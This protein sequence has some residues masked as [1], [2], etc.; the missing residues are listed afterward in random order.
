MEMTGRG[1]N[2]AVSQMPIPPTITANQQAAISS[3]LTKHLHPSLTEP[4]PSSSAAR[5]EAKVSKLSGPIKNDASFSAGKDEDWNERKVSSSKSGGSK[6][7]TGTGGD[8]DILDADLE[9][10]VD[11][12]GG[13]VD[14]DSIRDPKK[15]RLARKA[16][17]ARASRRRKKVYVNQLEDRVNQLTARITELEAEESS[18]GN[19]GDGGIYIPDSVKGEKKRLGPKTIKALQVLTRVYTYEQSNLG[20]TNPTQRIRRAHPEMEV[21]L[22][23]DWLFVL[24][25]C[26]WTI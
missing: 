2:A 3:L 19:D 15:K 26:R 23:D 12:V 21:L 18:L 20:H 5:K 25:S 10:N 9:E 16:E 13:D 6:T 1:T 17:L 11:D 24:M 22:N 7:G 8:D 4:A 14:L